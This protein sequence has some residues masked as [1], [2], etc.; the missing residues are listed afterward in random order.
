MLI[1]ISHTEI[2]E[3]EFQLI[4]SLFNKGLEYF[5]IRKPLFSFDE[6]KDFI[7]KIDNKFHQRIVIHNHYELI[8]EFNLKGIHGSIDKVNSFLIEND[9]LYSYSCHS[10]DEIKS[11]N[12]N[13]EYV[14]LSPL[15]DSISKQDY[16]AA[17][18]FKEL[19]IFLNQFN[20]NKK[21]IALG[22]LSKGNI[23]IAYNL[24][25]SGVALLGNIWQY[26]EINSFNTNFL[27][28]ANLCKIHFNM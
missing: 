10:F 14:F 4:H 2:I 5:H 20:L 27:E 11:I 24:G 16:K 3:N 21:I 22:G 15:F 28:I 12:S 17:F 1:V 18:D 19:K 7:N 23:P 13:P 26:S 9:C 25:F 6:T 8:N